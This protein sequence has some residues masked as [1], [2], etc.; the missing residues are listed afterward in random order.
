MTFSIDGNPI[1]SAPP[2][3]KNKSRQQMF[4]V[5]PAGRLT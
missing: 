2:E 1:L 3:E 4:D 5:V